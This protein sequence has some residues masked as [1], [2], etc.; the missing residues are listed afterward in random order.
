MLKI[1]IQFTIF[2]IIYAVMDTHTALEFLRRGI[3]ISCVPQMSGWSVNYIIILLKTM[4]Y[5]I[6]Y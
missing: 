3:S 6:V 5:Y 1:F 2:C 4:A